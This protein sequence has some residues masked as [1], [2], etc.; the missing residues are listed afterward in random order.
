MP[1]PLNEVVRARFK[2]QRTRDTSPELAVRRLLHAAG[3]R[4][5][6]EV[7]ADPD[8]RSKPDI[9]F[10]AVRVAVYIDGCFWHGCPEHFI[11]PKNNAEWWATKI[12]GN[13]ERDRIARADLF[14]RG[15]S[16]LSF[17]EHESP[18]VVAAA[19]GRAVES[20]RVGPSSTR[21]G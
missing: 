5:R 2:S 11:P 17:W 18:A 1:D 16:V 13:K 14:R 12:K 7:R 8:V 4:Y 6:V 3:F 20:R 15:W 21:P 19:V 10:R 9:V